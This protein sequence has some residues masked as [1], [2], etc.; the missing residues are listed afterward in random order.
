MSLQG[1]I[2]KEK[3]DNA[4]N[5]YSQT[6]KKQVNLTLWSIWY[7]E[8]DSLNIALQDAVKEYMDKNPNVTIK[9]ESTP[10]EAYK[11]KLNSAIAMN[12]APDIFFAWGNNYSKQF[13]EKDKVVDLTSHIENMNTKPLPGTMDSFTF[14]NKIYGLPLFGWQLGLYCNKELFDKYKVKIPETYDELLEAIKAFC[15]KGIAPMALG[16]NDRWVN[17]LYYMAL[18]QREAG[19]KK[20][21]DAINGNISF[22]QP[23]FLLAAYKL[24]NLSDQ[25]AFVENFL[26][27][28]NAEVETLFLEGKIPMHLMGSWLSSVI[29]KSDSKI[30]DN[31]EVVRFPVISKDKFANDTI[32]GFSDT[33]LVNSNSN[34]VEE[35]M[36]AY[37]EIIPSFSIKATQAGAGIPAW[38]VNM[39][40]ISSET[41]KKFFRMGIKGDY[42]AA[43]DMLLDADTVEVHLNSL[44]ELLAGV[45]TPEEYIKRHDE[46]INP[47]VR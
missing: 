4:S 43:Y 23:E 16:G 28:T 5:A 10:T 21:L 25:G 1:C 24:K 14:K 9:I 19:T 35:A 44:Q 38:E 39:E 2:Y 45:I 11:I 46:A 15:S 36:K 42:H 12:E 37:M 34:N 3:N 20:V 47:M 41:L 7:G 27:Y 17:S 31:V 29:D 32:G 26:H 40:D 30:K 18:A 13:I 6:A 8:E 33:F 22:N